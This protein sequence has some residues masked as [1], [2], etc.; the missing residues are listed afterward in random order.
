MAE[1]RHSLGRGF[2]P[3]QLHLR[4]KRW[5]RVGTAQITP[6]L[7]RNLK[8]RPCA[9]FFVS[10][11]FS[12]DVRFGEKRTLRG[13]EGAKLAGLSY[14]KRMRVGTAGTVQITPPLPRISY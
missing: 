10:A 14:R 1:G 5:G 7:P 9:G 8:T 13:G 6:P 11:I 3:A 2:L 12:F 4:R